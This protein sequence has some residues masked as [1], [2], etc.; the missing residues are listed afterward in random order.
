M[1]DVDALTEQLLTVLRTI[2]ELT[3]YD[4]RVPDNVPMSGI[5]IRPYVVLFSGLGGDL[6][7]R[8]RSLSLL[9][10][11][12][13]LSWQPQ[14]TVAGP[15][16]SSCRQAAQAVTAKLTNLPLGT[17][18]LIPNAEAFQADKPIS[19]TQV[20]PA[21]EFLPLHWRLITT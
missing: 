15:N 1:I 21:R 13:V 18:W 5:Y 3:V 11:P 2:P 17:G 9:A 10:D 20:T 12:T 16:A 19:D 14:T 7:E 4:N 8:E 6:G